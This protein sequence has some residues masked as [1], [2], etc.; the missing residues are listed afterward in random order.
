MVRL[1]AGKFLMGDDSAAAKPDE[2]PAHL[3]T[4][5]A[6]AA[7]KYEITYA[8]YAA[9]VAATERATPAYCR[10]DR[11]HDGI[12]RDDATATWRDP[13]FPQTDRHPVVCVSWADAS[14]YAAWLAGV[15][16]KPYRLLS[17]SE[18]EYA[19]RAGST[20]QF[21]W[22]DDPNLMCRYANGPDQ[23]ARSQ[24][25]QWEIAA[26]NDGQ[27][28]AAPVGSYRANGFGLYDT[29]GNVWEWTQ[30]CYEP[31]YGMQPTNG[32]AYEG[33]TCRRRALRGGSWVHGLSDLRSSQRN[34][35]PP[36]QIRG[37]D[38]GFRVARSL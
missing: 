19:A 22:G 18:W 23:A 27:V 32:A 12:W 33:G 15:T 3:V 25:P 35:L 11:S 13:G 29:A 37:G 10:T 5:P 7:G 31:S 34:G 30:D 21:W 2:K 38:I 8:E 14:A 9:F 16:G 4:V 6:F 28:F 36:P 24:F 20:N 17:E 1:P 26:C